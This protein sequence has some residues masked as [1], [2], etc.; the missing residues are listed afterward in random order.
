MAEGNKSLPY[1]IIHTVRAC[2]RRLGLYRFL[3]GLKEK[4]VPLSYVVEL[5]CVYQL[6]G[7]C[8]MNECGALSGSVLVREELCHGHT[9]SRKTIERGLFLLDLYFEETMVHLWH[10]L[11]E[12]YPDLST[13]VYVDG[14]HIPRE[15][16]GRGAYT[17]AGEGGGSVQLQDQFM[18]AQLV[19][20]GLPISVEVYRGNLNDPPQYADFVP[21]LMF[22]LNQGSMIIMDHGGSAKDLLREIRDNDMDYLTRV[23][24]NRSDIG[25]IRREIGDAEYVGTGTMC[26]HHGFE[27][28][29]RHTYLYFSVDRYIMG[30]LLAERRALRL[31]DMARDAKEYVEKQDTRKVVKPIKNPFFKVK[32]VKVEVEMTLNPWMEEDVAKAIKETEKDDCGWFKLE[33]SKMLTPL[34]A[35]DPYRHR[36]GIEALISSIKSVVNMKPLRVWSAS[37][38]R[39]AVMLGMIAQLCVSMV[40]HD[41]EPD[42]IIK[43][44]DGRVVRVDHKPSTATI[45][46][47]LSHWTVVLIPRDDFKIERIYTDENDLTRRISAVLDGYRGC[48]TVLPGI[49]DLRKAV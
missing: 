20:S 7:G 26:I 19:D 10:R 14:S 30:H 2:F 44:I 48:F 12:I 11:N 46:K 8:S 6:N 21:Q 13:D 42:Q 17:A 39:G 43:R 41:M 1:G 28:S 34:Q 35:L 33:S 3:D 29:D 4:G 40:R 15:G 45:C 25:R 31:M 32:S 16:A 22:M 38:T 5:M 23:R 24:M 9:I 27:S 18:I 37:S 36:A 49:A 47:N